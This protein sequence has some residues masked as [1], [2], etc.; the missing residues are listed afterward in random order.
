MVE[1]CTD[2]SIQFE[3]LAME[4]YV[5]SILRVDGGPGDRSPLSFPIKL[6]P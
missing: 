5:A 1:F 6:G 3:V 2:D 4:T